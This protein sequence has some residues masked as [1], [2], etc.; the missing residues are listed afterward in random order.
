MAQREKIMK[1]Y[2]FPG[3]RGVLAGMALCGAFALGHAEA[4]TIS[5]G[6]MTL[7][8]DR[9]ALIAG[10]IQDNYPDAP[11]ETFPVCCRPSLYL[12]EYF[13]ATAASKTSGQLRDENTPDLYDSVSD[14]IS[15]LGLQFQVNASSI[16]ANPLGRQNKAN[17]FSFDPANLSGTATGQIGLGGVMRFR[18]DVDPPNNR[19]L[20][21]DLDLEYIPALANPVTGQSGWILMNNIGFRIAGFDLFDVSTQLNGNSLSLSGILGLGSGFDHLGGIRDTR[22]G[23]FNFQTT[24]VPLPAAFWLFASGMLGLG[25]SAYRKRWT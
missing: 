16:P 2:H 24:V 6:V 13:D 15:A 11:T 5:G 7:N 18:V 4:A 25:A 19:V 8:L 20:L 9:N 14:E 23:T 12:E 17:T 22:V 21:G 1:K 10:V 3:I